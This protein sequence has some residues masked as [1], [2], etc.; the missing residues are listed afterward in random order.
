MEKTLA[1]IKPDAFPRAGKILDAI[2]R[3]GF[4]IANLRSLKLSMADAEEFYAEHR[5]KVP[6]ATAPGASACQAA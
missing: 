4:R 3:D 2:Y 1:L 6:P 5:G